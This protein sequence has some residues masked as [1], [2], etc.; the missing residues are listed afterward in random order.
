MLVRAFLDDRRRG[1]WKVRL[2]GAAPE[3][4]APPPVNADDRTVVRAA[5][6]QVPRRQQGPSSRPGSRMTVIQFLV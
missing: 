5:L 4:P 1:W 3:P 6:A 2:F